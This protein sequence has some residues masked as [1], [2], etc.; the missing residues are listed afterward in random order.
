MPAAAKHSKDVKTAPRIIHILLG[1]VF[2]LTLAISIFAAG[3]AVCT[4][5]GTTGVL[6]RLFSNFEA[7]AYLP[8]DITELALATRAFTVEHHRAGDAEASAALARE[9]LAAAERSSAQTSPKASRWTNVTFSE[10]NTPIVQMYD[11]ASAGSQFALG[12]SEI[13]HLQDCNKLIR[14]A[15]P[16]LVVIVVVALASGI[17]LF[18]TSGKRPFGRALTAAPAVLLTALVG[19]AIWALVDFYGFFSAFHGLFFPQG[20]WTFPAESL[21]IC[22]LPTP[23]WIGMVAIW[24]LISIFLS[25]SAVFVGRRLC[26]SYS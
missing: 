6:S 20:N 2:S 26:R 4:L 19:I 23:F 13:S 21:L 25:I 5:P 7:S 16:V 15:I 8:E 10:S 9:V 17:F 14:S 18:A 22:M 11:L 12:P 3:F 1:V 24:A